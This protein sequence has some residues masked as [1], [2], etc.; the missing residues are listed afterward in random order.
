MSPQAVAAAATAA[1][2]LAGSG[3]DYK[4]QKAALEQAEKDRARTIGLIEQY[5]GNAIE[6]LTP[7]YQ[8]AQ[9][10]Q[11]QA[12]NQGLNL[13]G[14]VFRP[15]VDTIQ[16]GDYMAQQAAIAGMMGQ[17]NAI[18]GDSI[19][20]GAL[21][22]Q[23][24]PVN[25]N[26]LT[27]LTSPQTLDYAN[28]EVP[29]YGALTRSD[30]IAAALAAAQ[31]SAAQDSASRDSSAL[32]GALALGAGGIGLGLAI[33]SLLAAAGTGGFGAAVSG[34]GATALGAVRGVLGGAGAAVG[35]LLSNPLTWGAGAL[36]LAVKNDFWK[37]PDG[38]VRS[39]SGLLVG[40]TPAAEGS[41]RAFSIEPFE[42]G[43]QG[44]GF[45]RRGSQEDANKII[46]VF[47]EADSLITKAAR[48][49]GGNIDLSKATLNG[50]NEDGQYGTS[51]TFLGVGGKTSNLDL[52]V[53]FYAQQLAN[54]I[55]GL[56]ADTLKQL[57]SA[58]TTVDIVNILENITATDASS[59]TKQAATF[60]TE[61]VR[62][63]LNSGSAG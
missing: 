38:Y 56:D 4:A 10:I 23:N 11:Q 31:N 13:T 43:F 15:M 16:S 44:T 46:D 17:R 22:P 21:Q 32:G 52:Q 24:V 39:N 62:N 18:L 59:G 27:G 50:V 40:P 37:D 19:N 6:S 29:D 33:P 51:G 54:T 58:E 41:D 12:T 9:N 26:S 3:L 36:L 48:N 7:G 25:F 49:A 57:K 63:A 35:T 1:A 42:S 53:D 2:S 55:T 28:F 5:G 20:Y 47:R 34:L 14:Q 60:S 8:N 45:N 30:K 61:Q